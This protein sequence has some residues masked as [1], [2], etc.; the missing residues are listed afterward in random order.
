MQI[1]DPVGSGDCIKCFNC[2]TSESK[3]LHSATTRLFTIECTSIYGKAVDTFHRLNSE[4]LISLAGRALFNAFFS[5]CLLVR[6]LGFGEQDCD[7]LGFGTSRLA[8]S[9]FSDGIAIAVLLII[10][11]Y[12]K[13]VFIILRNKYIIYYVIYVIWWLILL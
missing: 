11:Q 10:L 13:F 12:T 1:E 7:C 6:F 2:T 8:K 3:Q 9:V 5:F 4:T